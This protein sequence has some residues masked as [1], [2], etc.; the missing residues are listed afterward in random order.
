ML[1]PT[2]AYVLLAGLA[3]QSLATNSIK[4]Y[5]TMTNRKPAGYVPTTTQT[6]YTPCTTK[7]T[8]TSTTTKTPKTTKTETKYENSYV[9]DPNKGTST[10]TV[11]VT[12]S[13]TSVTGTTTSTSTTT[14]TTSVTS[15]S[16]A[17]AP[18]TFTPIQS[19]LPDSSNSGSAGGAPMRKR[20]ESRLSNRAPK[21]SYGRAYPKKV[22]CHKYTKNR[23]CQTKKVTTTKTVYAHTETHTKKITKTQTKTKCPEAKKTIT[24]TVNTVKTTTVGTI[25]VTLTATS[26][27]TT[28]VA[29]T[30]INAACRL[31]SNYADEV[32]GSDLVEANPFPSRPFDF[33]QFEAQDAFACCNAAF[34]PRTETDAVV[35]PEIFAFDRRT[36]PNNPSQIIGFCTVVGS[37]TCGATQE[38]G[39][40]E[41]LS[42]D[43]AGPG[44]PDQVGVVAGPVFGNAPCGEAIGPQG[45]ER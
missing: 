1:L 20:A 42:E 10:V 39:Q 16:T 7:Q 43:Q 37:E 2:T 9:T 12:T 21:N 32:N 4:C 38:D 5:T 36:D 8:Y 44:E 18:A 17:P 25:T 35:G 31:A 33:V 3:G 40:W 23:T 19:S 13:T 15:T 30:T 27:T 26:T 14:T 41:L 24:S 22:T 45:N 34:S 11:T 6:H 29:T 28:A